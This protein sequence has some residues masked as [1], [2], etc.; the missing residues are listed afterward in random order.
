MVFGVDHAAIGRWLSE[1]WRLPAA[2]VEPLAF[3]HRPAAAPSECWGLVVAVHLADILARNAGIGSGGDALVPLPDGEVMARLRI[4][5]ADLS[6]W[7]AGLDAE[8][9]SVQTFFEV[10]R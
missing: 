8:R 1:R 10:M 9:E 6:R 3:H 5:S 4:G 2:I 7:T